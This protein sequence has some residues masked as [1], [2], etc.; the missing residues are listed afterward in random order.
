M[1]IDRDRDRIKIE[2]PREKMREREGIIWFEILGPP[3]IAANVQGFG[4]VG[5]RVLVVRLAV[6][7]VY[8]RPNY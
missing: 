1:D 2:I 7:F 4:Q 6:T 3:Q 5:F 8:L